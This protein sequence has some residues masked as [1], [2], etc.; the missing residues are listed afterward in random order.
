[1]IHAFIDEHLAC[2]HILSLCFLNCCQELEEHWDSPAGPPGL[3]WQVSDVTLDEVDKAAPP[4]E[5]TL[6]ALMPMASGFQE[7]PWLSLGLPFL[8]TRPLH[9]SSNRGSYISHTDVSDISHPVP[10]STGGLPMGLS[11]LIPGARAQSQCPST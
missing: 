2:F 5:K 3:T 7:T 8:K 10:R 1:M 4:E 6:P 9:P 11:K